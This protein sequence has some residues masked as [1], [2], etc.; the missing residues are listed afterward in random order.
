MPISQQICKYG[1][2]DASCI[3][4]H[5][6]ISVHNQR[7]CCTVTH[8]IVHT[9]IEIQLRAFLAYSFRSLR[10]YKGSITVGDW[11]VLTSLV[12]S[13]H[14]PT[15]IYIQLTNV[16]NLFSFL[17]FQISKF[18]TQS[19]TYVSRKSECEQCLICQEISSHFKKLRNQ[20]IYESIHSCF[21]LKKISA[22]LQ[23]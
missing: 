17:F 10:K 23:I 4:V 12:R 1:N 14:R 21:F 18:K 22:F 9:W 7:S 19:L 3:F 16:R 13:S 20:Y 6:Q 11:D 5:L 15:Y 8:I 2:K